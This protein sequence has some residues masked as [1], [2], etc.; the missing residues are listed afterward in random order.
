M[1]IAWL[2]RM[3]RW[4]QNPPSK[5]RVKLVFWIIVILAVIFGIEYFGYWPEWATSER[6]KLR[7]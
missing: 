2:M 4:V 3:R 7:F 1:N 5:E 6:L